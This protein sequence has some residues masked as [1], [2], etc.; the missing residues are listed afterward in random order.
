MYIVLAYQTKLDW[1]ICYPCYDGD[2]VTVT[3]QVD[4]WRNG[5][6]DKTNGVFVSVSMYYIHSPKLNCEIHGNGTEI[7][8]KDPSALPI[9]KMVKATVGPKVYTVIMPLL[10]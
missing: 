10:W 6:I 4:G 9:S 2:N 3:T 8:Y 1:I 5:A 7:R